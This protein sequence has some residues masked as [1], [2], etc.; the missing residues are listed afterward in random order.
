MS[1]IKNLTIGVGLD[2]KVANMRK[3]QEFILYPYKGGDIIHLQSDKRFIELNL[4]TGKAVIN[5]KNTNYANMIAVQCNP[6]HFDFPNDELTEIKQY[7]WNKNGQKG[8]N[9]IVEYDNKPLYSK[10]NENK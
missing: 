4:R 1:K 9:S 8:G 3:Q 2:L 6:L 7:L 5:K 10:N